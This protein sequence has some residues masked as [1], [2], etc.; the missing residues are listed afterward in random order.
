MLV[1]EG[2]TE[3][4]PGVMQMERLFHCSRTLSSSLGAEGPPWAPRDR[5]RETGEPRVQKFSRLVLQGL[6][7]HLA[8]LETVPGKKRHVSS[9]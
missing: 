5:G 1:L 7:P 6:W 3:G 4:P 8:E 9:Y 2:G